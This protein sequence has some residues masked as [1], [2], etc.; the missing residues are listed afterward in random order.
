MTF[1][2]LP[3]PVVPPPFLAED[4]ALLNQLQ[5][6]ARILDRDQAYHP[7]TV[8]Q[9]LTTLD[10][11]GPSEAGDVIHSLFWHATLVSKRAHRFSLE[12]MALQAELAALKQQAVPSALTS[13]SQEHSNANT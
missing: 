2:S 11:T 5:S 9:V 4:S 6:R 10:S 12:I 1:D 7:T 3:G 8:C 13:V